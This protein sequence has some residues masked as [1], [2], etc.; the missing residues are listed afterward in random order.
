MGLLIG[1]AIS[2]PDYA[3]KAATVSYLLDTINAHAAYSWRKLKSTATLC[4]R[5]RRSSDNAET[6]IGF[7]GTIWD[8][9]AITAFVGAS[10]G[11][12]RTYYDQ[13]GNGRNREINVIAAQ[14]QLVSSGTILKDGAYPYLDF[15]S[16]SSTIYGLDGSSTPMFSSNG[17][18]TS[19]MVYKT[20][21]T[22]S[23][24]YRFGTAYWMLLAISGDSSAAMSAGLSTLGTF[25]KNG[26]TV[27]VANRNALYTTFNNG[28][29]LLHEQ[30]GFQFSTW[31][32]RYFHL[33]GYGGADSWIGRWFEEIIMSGSTSGATQTTITNNIKTAYGL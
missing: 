22:R 30:N 6:D 3:K 11:F 12:I 8:E 19:F 29:I 25:R 9:A 13:S 31:S 27:T 33:G 15:N 26:N 24:I 7:N 18:W 2:I 17:P 1:N 20:S 4:M 28:Q 10:N 32:P 21:D 14:P 5:I 16:A 23:V